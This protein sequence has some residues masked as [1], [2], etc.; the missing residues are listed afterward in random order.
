MLEDLYVKKSIP[1]FGEP[2][3][4]YKTVLRGYLD[5]TP[6]LDGWT[7]YDLLVGGTTNKVLK[8]TVGNEHKVLRIWNKDARNLGIYRDCEVFNSSI[9]NK[10]NMAPEV[11]YSNLDRGLMVTEY[12]DGV[13]LDNDN[14][15]NII[16]LSKTIQ[17]IKKLHSGPRFVNDFDIFDLMD[18]FLKICKDKGYKLS[19]NYYEHKKNMYYMNKIRKS[20]AKSKGP[21]VACHNDLMANNI[22]VTSK[23]TK[24]IDFEYSGN[25]DPCYELGH[26]W[27]ESNTDIHKLGFIVREYFGYWDEKNLNKAKLYAI[28]SS[29]TWYLWG[30]IQHNLKN[31]NYKWEY[32]YKKD[33]EFR[34]QKAKEKLNSKI[35]NNIL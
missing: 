18:K 17:A 25:N 30:V 19:E 6:E 28:A 14:L 35:L 9:A 24:F 27:V 4:S 34:Y 15:A 2:Y 5:R 26:L 20:L 33:Y 23:G 22:I 8:V 13:V 32:D 29:Y 7:R 16:I 10:I 3:Q 21:T 11:L 31:N 12:L 1:P